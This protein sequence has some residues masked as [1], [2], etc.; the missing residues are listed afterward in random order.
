L[1]IYAVEVLARLNETI[2]AIDAGYR[3]YQFNAV[4]Q[5]LYD[6]FWG[7]YCDWFVEAAKTDIFAD[8]EAGKRSALAVMDMVLS[9]F[10]RLLHPFMP[11]ITEE[12][13]SVL[14]LGNDSIQFALPPVRTP[15]EDVDLMRKRRLVSNIYQTVQAGRNLRS[16]V[17]LPF[18]KKLRFI[19]RTNEKAISAEIPTIG[20][21]LNAEEI[22][23]DRKYQPKA[24][25]PVAVT[26]LGEIFLAI[27]AA[28]KAGEEERLDK[29]IAKIE[30]E[31]RKVEGKLKNRSF[32]DRAPRA[33]VEEHRR[34]L[35]DFTA[36]LAKL[37][38]AREART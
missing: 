16:E 27:T 37:R 6:F 11:H 28:D 13:W 1:S 17:K 33:V 21:L 29:E 7:D 8:N 22:T 35:K 31:L 18:N 3:D 30:S 32:V 10:L 12:L 20:R 4:A 14:G 24:S 23:L 9:A 19:L 25:N 5:S 2:D 36:Q 34:R 26:P 38:Q 15:L